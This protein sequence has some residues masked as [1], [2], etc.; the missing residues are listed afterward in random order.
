VN[1]I[2][3]NRPLAREEVKTM[4]KK[5]I[6]SDVAEATVSLLG[7]GGQGV[8]V[9]NNLIL[10]AAHCINFN[11]DGGMALGD[12][13]IEEIETSDGGKLKVG[14][15]AVEPV[16]DI[17][18]LGSLDDQEFTDEATKFEHFCEGKKPLSLCL[19][20][21]GWSVEVP[22]WVYTHKKTWIRGKMINY[23]IKKN[24]HKISIKMD[25]NIEGGT[26]GSPIINEKGELMG[27]VSNA[28]GSKGINR[29]G[30]VPFPI[31][32]LPIWLYQ[33]ITAPDPY[34]LYFKIT[35]KERE[36]LI[37]KLKRKRG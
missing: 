35:K 27:V 11:Y 26:S 22:I 31:F 5:S 7:K 30:M 36:Q 37:E 16:S 18:V 6:Q 15:Y 14:P 2:N 32:A 9:R 23:S 25:E 19:K 21:F 24:A 33:E 12:Y 34:S 29:E 10:T 3:L 20:K 13:F 28:G 1:P 17:A 4:L 8:L